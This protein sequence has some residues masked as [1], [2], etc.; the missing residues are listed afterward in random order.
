MSTLVCVLCTVVLDGFAEPLCTV[1]KQDNY[2]L[3]VGGVWHAF[4]NEGR[5]H[6]GTAGTVGDLPSLARAR[7]Q[8]RAGSPS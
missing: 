2:V 5:L 7:R 8:R 1:C 3:L 6:G 4:S